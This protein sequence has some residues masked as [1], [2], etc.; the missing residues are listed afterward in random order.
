MLVTAEEAQVDV[1]EELE[2]RRE[3][4]AEA[5]LT[6]SD[7]GELRVPPLYAPAEGITVWLENAPALTVQ[8]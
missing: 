4:L 8:N 2:D 6:R 3:T 7:V 5:W 1:P